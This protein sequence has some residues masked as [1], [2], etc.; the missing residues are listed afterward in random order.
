MQG[1]KK[2]TSK[3][4]SSGWVLDI[5]KQFKRQGVKD[6]LELSSD[7]M[8]YVIIK[9]KLLEALRMKWQDVRMSNMEHYIAN[10]LQCCPQYQGKIP[11]YIQLYLTTPM[12]FGSWRTLTL[13]QTSSLKLGVEVGSWNYHPN[14][15]ICKVCIEILV[16]DEY[17][18][19]IASSA[20]K[21][22]CE[23]YGDLLSGMII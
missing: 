4:L 1:S 10:Y 16:E 6:L 11:K 21:V 19:L 17:H 9:N 7:A 15:K 13:L 12:S 2:N 23:K 22:I 3:I 5:M 14:M 18:L 20:D 8:E